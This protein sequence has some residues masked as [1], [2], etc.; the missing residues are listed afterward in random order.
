M[1]KHTKRIAIPAVTVLAAGALTGALLWGNT[2]GADPM[3]PAVDV[4]GVLDVTDYC[5]PGAEEGAFDGACDD[6]VAALQQLDAGK[7]NEDHL[8]VRVD[9]ERIDPDASGRVSYCYNELL[10]ANA[11]Y[12]EP[13]LSNAPGSEVCDGQGVTPFPSG[14]VVVKDVTVNPTVR[15]EGGPAALSFQTAHLDGDGV[16]IT[17]FD[18]DGDVVT[19]PVVITVQ[20][21]YKYA[22]A[23]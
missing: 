13:A 2:A 3:D 17:V 5:E 9:E 1:K 8:V 10:P 11:D 14:N 20:A 18:R 7:K 21:T 19:N 22:P 16:V 15:A 23:A 4:D 6:I 12:P